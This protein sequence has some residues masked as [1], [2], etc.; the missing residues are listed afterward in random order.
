MN[1]TV[2][3]LTPYGWRRHARAHWW[4]IKAAAEQQMKYLAARN[5]GKQF[6]LE[7]DEYEP[8]PHRQG[9]KP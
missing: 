1:W 8:S 5:P 7:S 2:H 9:A 3:V 4:H 6:R